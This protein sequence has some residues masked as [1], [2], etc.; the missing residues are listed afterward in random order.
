MP[1][2]SCDSSAKRSTSRSD[3]G[4][5]ASPSGAGGR[6]GPDPR[7]RSR[8]RSGR[9][10]NDF[11]AIVVGAG[12]VG[13]G[14]AFALARANARVALLDAGPAAGPIGS[15]PGGERGTSRASFAWINATAKTDQEDYHRLNARGAEHYRALAREFGE[16]RLG[17]HP[18]GMIAWANPGDEERRQALRGQV[19]RLREWSYPV[20]PLDADALR[21]LEPHVALAPGAEGLLAYCDA[22]LDVPR[23]VDLLC[24]EVR[25]RGGT[26]IAG[27]RGRVT[28]L[29]R[30]EAGALRGVEAGGGRLTAPVV[31]TAL[32]PDTE[33]LLR[34]WLRPGELGNRAFLARRP[35]LLVDTPD[36]GPFR[37]VRHV[38][39]TGDNAFHLRPG[40]SGGLRIGSEDADPESEAPD[41]A[42]ARALALLARARA[43]VP[44]LG[45]D[46]PLETLA[47][48]C[49]VR[50]GV[51]PVPTDDRTIIGPVASV[52]GL[53]VIVTH[54]GVTL[55]PYLGRLA[56]EEITSGKMPGRLAP[57]RFDRLA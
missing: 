15:S 56:A 38:L 32:G 23:A 57:F 40:P 17:L 36:T 2:D 25:R 31:V 21:A 6:A 22:W 24:G 52:R 46:A 29:L 47:R 12:I 11:D 44:G 16:A 50:I 9:P 4:T 39:Y 42:E 20:T 18:T 43:L 27:G 3:G 5:D 13:A 7:H 28:G 49:T 8:S 45:G 14:A 55:G 48:E 26:V 41:D 53:Y 1:G 51:R 33:N 19:E 35:G 30:D 54:S 37:L 10:V 34:A